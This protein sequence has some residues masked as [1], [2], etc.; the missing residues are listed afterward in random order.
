MPKRKAVM[1]YP[2]KGFL[3]GVSRVLDIRKTPADYRPNQ[4]A[5]EGYDLFAI[6]LVEILTG[7]NVFEVGFPQLYVG[8]GRL[9]DQ[10]IGLGQFGPR[11]SGFH[12]DVES[13]RCQKIPRWKEKFR[14][15]PPNNKHHNYVVLIINIRPARFHG[16]CQSILLIRK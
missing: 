4:R 12:A 6:A 8:F 13:C 10:V 9:G 11:K 3:D 16:A 14:K 1:K 2:H 15:D 7:Q 5:K